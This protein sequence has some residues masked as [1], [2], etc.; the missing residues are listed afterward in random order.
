MPQTNRIKCSRCLVWFLLCFNLQFAK[1]P[2]VLVPH[3]SPKFISPVGQVLGAKFYAFVGLFV[4]VAVIA[5]MMMRR[6]AASDAENRLA[7]RNAAKDE[8][9][10]AWAR[11]TPETMPSICLRKYEHAFDALQARVSSRLGQFDA[12]LQLEKE[13]NLDKHTLSK[14]LKWKETMHV[15]LPSHKS[16]KSAA[17]RKAVERDRRAAAAAKASELSEE[18]RLR[19]KEAAA[20]KIEEASPQ[21][22]LPS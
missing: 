19:D 12:L 14:Y 18:Q 11:F 3:E 4:V 2:P 20:K 17:E 5:T 15:Q 13:F 1:A 16:P 6:A 9:E 7:E 22:S 21:A 8:I 10:E